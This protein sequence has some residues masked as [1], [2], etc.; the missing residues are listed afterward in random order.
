[1]YLNS[2]VVYL[3]GDVRLDVA[4]TTELLSIVVYLTKDVKYE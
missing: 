4:M 3:I 2:S 1:M